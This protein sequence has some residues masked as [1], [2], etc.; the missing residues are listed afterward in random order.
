MTP[1][2]QT[3]TLHAILQGLP[4][5]LS[6]E[7]TLGHAGTPVQTEPTLENVAIDFPSQLDPKAVFRVYAYTHW[8]TL[9]PTQL[10]PIRHRFSMPDGFDY[11]NRTGVAVG[12]A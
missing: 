9:G 3:L 12:S 5:K 1:R 11:L 6:N 7:S 4:P 8:Q 10:A 2:T